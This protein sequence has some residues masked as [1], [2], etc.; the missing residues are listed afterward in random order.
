MAELVDVAIC[1]VC[2]GINCRHGQPSELMV[3]MPAEQQIAFLEE[4]LGHLEKRLAELE[5]GGKQKT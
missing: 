2:G 4:A 1:A 5:S 3:K